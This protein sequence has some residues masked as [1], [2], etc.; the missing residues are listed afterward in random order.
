MLPNSMD[1][2]AVAQAPTGVLI[3]P[4]EFYQKYSVHSFHSVFEFNLK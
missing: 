2:T 1:S 4:A 3:G